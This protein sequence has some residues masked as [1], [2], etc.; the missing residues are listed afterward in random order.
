MRDYPLVD[1]LK[2]EKD[3]SDDKANVTSSL[4]TLDET[5]DVGRNSQ[6]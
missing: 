5:I 2:I 3:T 1:A 6:I 4:Y